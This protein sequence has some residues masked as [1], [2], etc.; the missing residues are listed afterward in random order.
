M[1]LA[2]LKTNVDKLDI[3]KLRYI[4]SNLSNLKSK[5]HKLDVDKLKFVPVGLSKQSDVVKNDVVKK[6]VYNA[7][8]KDIEDKIPDITNLATNT[9]LN[10]RINEV[11]IKLPNIT[12]LATTSALTAVENKIPNVCNLLK[13]TGYSTK[14][15]KIENEFTTDYDHFKYITTQE[16][17]KLTSKTSTAKLAQANLASRSDTANFVKKTDFDNKLKMLLQIKMN[18]MNYQ[19]EY[20][21]KE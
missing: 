5:V 9:T 2:S 20:Q 8:I 11:R 6:D 12:N 14:I 16:F 1:D 13:K 17:N 19:K 15:S 4:T 10:A 3:D 7:K 21:Q 18:L